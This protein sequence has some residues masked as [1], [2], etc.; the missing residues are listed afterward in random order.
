MKHRCRAS[1]RGAAL[2]EAAV[3]MP[4]IVTFLGM[5]MWFHNLH[6]VEQDTALKARYEALSRASHGCGVGG[7]NFADSSVSD[8]LGPGDGSNALA[9]AGK[10][11]FQ[12]ALSLLFS[13]S[14]VEE[15]GVAQGGLFASAWTHD[16]HHTS[17]VMCNEPKYPDGLLGLLPFATNIAMGA[18]KNIF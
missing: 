4:V 14:T 15:H 5:M 3:V 8:A 16:V 18:I 1:H 17:K 13:P 12:G 6:V 9:A 11:L 7:G 10:G 2:V